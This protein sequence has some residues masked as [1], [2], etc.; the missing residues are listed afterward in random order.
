MWRETTITGASLVFALGLVTISGVVPVVGHSDDDVVEEVEEV[1]VV[2]ES[3]V[4][5]VPSDAAFNSSFSLSRVIGRNHPALVHI[6]IGMLVALV[7]VE[8]LSM[9]RPGL[10]MGKSGMVLSIVT[11]FSFIPAA[12]S[13]LIRAGEVFADRPPSPLMLEHRNL[14]IAAFSACLAAAVIRWVKKDALKGK[15][16]LLYL[17]LVVLSLLLTGLGGHHGGQLVYGENYLPY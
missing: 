5:A 3:P 1:E 14:M 11:A 7:L 15:L 12:V 16:R 10:D 9:I 6:A 4:G 17:G 8:L 2:A 13:G